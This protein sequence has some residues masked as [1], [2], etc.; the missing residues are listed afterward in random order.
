MFDKPIH[1]VKKKDEGN[2]ARSPDT[3]VGIGYL[4]QNCLAQV[5]RVKISISHH[6][7]NVYYIHYLVGSPF[8]WCLTKG[9]R[10]SSLNE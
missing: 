1:F 2:S 5:L 7:G 9:W 10:V 8:S 3:N 4:N 6:V